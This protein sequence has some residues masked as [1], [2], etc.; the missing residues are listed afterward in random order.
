M[1]DDETELDDYPKKRAT[2][3]QN[4]IQNSVL[5]QFASKNSHKFFEIL[6][7]PLDFLNK[8]PSDWL[9][10]DTYM[11]SFSIASKLRVVNDNTERD[12]SLIT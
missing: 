7:L 6:G 1:N 3:Y 11:R 10:D 2:L 4:Q 9:T 5:E 8:D 12:V